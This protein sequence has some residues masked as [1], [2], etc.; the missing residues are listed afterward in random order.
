MWVLHNYILSIKYAKIT[1][2]NKGIASSSMQ[3]ES[4]PLT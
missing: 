4:L 3:S 1:P 2:K